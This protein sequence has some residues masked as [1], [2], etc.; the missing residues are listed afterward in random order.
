[1][2][3]LAQPTVQLPVLGLGATCNVRIMINRGVIDQ[4]R[5]EEIVILMIIIIITIILNI[6]IVIINVSNIINSIFTFWRGIRASIGWQFVCFV[7][8]S[9]CFCTQNVFVS[10]LR[11]PFPQTRKLHWQDSC[12]RKSVEHVSL[13]RIPGSFYLIARQGIIK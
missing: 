7:T 5:F 2:L 4:S 13:H 3:G 6:I 9:D 8:D 11:I 1:M 10:F 12:D